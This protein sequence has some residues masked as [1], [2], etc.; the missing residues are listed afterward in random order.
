[1]AGARYLVRFDDICPT[2]DWSIWDRIEPLL[3]DFNVKPIVA[4][5]PN[6]KDEKLKVMD[7]RLDFWERAR[8]WQKNNW[9]IALHGYEHLYETNDSGLVGINRVSEFAGLSY[10]VQQRKLQ[11]AL[12]IFK[13]NNINPDAWVAP[14]HSFDQDTVRILIENGLNIISDG[15][16]IRPIRYMNAIWLPQQMWKFRPMPMGIW[17]ICYHSNSFSQYDLD[18]LENDLKRYQKLIISVH[19]LQLTAC[20]S[21]RTTFDWLF[22]LLWLS[23]VKT[24]RRFHL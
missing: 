1:M 22:N 18:L 24:K 12:R 8:Y 11:A 5:V 17:T 19:D 7:A 3:F 9:C 6:N 10:D 14:A 16:F 23:A 21:T 13:D 4:I 2:M 15:Y 20:T